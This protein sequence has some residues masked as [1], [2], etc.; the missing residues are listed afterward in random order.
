MGAKMLKEEEAKSLAENQ[1]NGRFA[2][3]FAAC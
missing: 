3:L 2:C 1:S